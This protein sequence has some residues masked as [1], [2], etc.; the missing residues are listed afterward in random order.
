MTKKEI[1]IRLKQAQDTLDNVKKST[2]THWTISKKN[3]I[4]YCEQTII[5]CDI[6]LTEGYYENISIR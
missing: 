2:K 3:M 4:N 6:L 1:K 5:L